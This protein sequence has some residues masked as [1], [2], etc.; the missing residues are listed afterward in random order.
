MKLFKKILIYTLPVIIIGGV[1]W[2]IISF[3]GKSILGTSDAKVLRAKEEISLNINKKDQPAVNIPA[4]KVPEFTLDLTTQKLKTLAGASKQ[5]LEELVQATIVHKAFANEKLAAEINVDQTGNKLMVN[6]KDIP[7]F[8]PGLYKLSLKLRTLEGEV[9]IEQDFTWGVIAVNSNKSIYKPGDVATIGMGVLNDAGETQCMTGQ[10]RADLWLTVTAPNGSIKEY[11]TESGSIKDSGE[12]G[13]I[14]VTNTPDAVAI[15]L[16]DDPGIYTMTVTARIKGG[17]KRTIKDYFKAEAAPAFD[18]ERTSFPTRIYP[19]ASYPVKL[20]ITAMTNDYSG[21]VED[22]VP[23]SFQ[24]SNING[25][26]HEEIQG[27]FKKIIWNTNLRRGQQTMFTYTINFPLVSPEFYLLGPLKIGD[28]EEARQWQIASDAVNSTT[29]VL[30]YEN[31]NGSNTYYRIWSGTAF[32]AQ[33][34]MDVTGDTPD[35]SRWF[36]E[37]TSPKTGEKL[38]AAFDNSSAPV[39]ATERIWMYRWNGSA[40]F[41]DFFEDVN[42]NDNTTRPM[43]IAYEEDSG[44][45]LFVFSN[46]TNQLRYRTKPNLGDGSTWSA[47]GS[48]GTALGARKRWVVAKPQPNSDNILVGYLNESEF[49]GALVWNG[50]SDTFTNQLNDDAGTATAAS[51]EQSF[52]IAWEKQSGTP[53]IFWGNT[54]QQLVY[55]EFTGGAWSSPAVLYTTDADAANDI[56][57][58]AAASDPDPTSNYI[59]LAMQE[60]LDD[61]ATDEAIDCEF[62]MWNGTGGETLPSPISCRSD[63]DGRLN[64]V[65]FEN[66]GGRAIF[67]YNTS[68]DGNS[69]AYR[70][71]QAGD[72]SP[73]TSTAITGDTTGTIESIQLYSDP[74]STS[75]LALFAADSNDADTDPDVYY[76]GWDGTSWDTIASQFGRIQG[77]GE[78]AEAYGFGFDR[79][80]ELQAAYRWITASGTTTISSALTTQDTAYTLTSANQQFRLRLLLYFPDT[81]LA[82][83]RNFI[84]QYVDPGTGTCADPTGGTPSTWTDVAAPGSPGSTEISYYDNS[85]PD[86]GDNL[87]G[88]ASLDP[89]YLSYD[90]SDSS[91]IE[92]DYEEGTAVSNPLFFTNSVSAMSNDQ[93]ALWDFSLID[94]TTFDRIAQ[95]YCFRVARA[96]GSNRLPLRVNVY[97]QINTAAES[98]VLIRGG[99]LIQGG[100]LLQ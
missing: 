71:W 1:V 7:G 38:V 94:N 69:L 3:S 93:V 58:V 81:L 46:T 99:S 14:T 5:K 53:M 2:G 61:D 79:N 16:I 4:N 28:F 21:T 54:T 75:I 56:E 55:S 41:E 11:S 70:T 74:N 45:A 87:V 73:G 82:S 63:N 80:L 27:D 17:E 84:L 78:N 20:S 72:A 68:A 97:P 36:V 34:D 13:P 96:S 25:G 85:T 37:K 66:T 29:G 32:N 9:N 39:A 10:D 92:Q 89:T 8:K 31:N 50:S 15:Y 91:Y 64:N 18:V 76:V 86:D 42:N 47:T 30:S 95:T 57:W 100:T 44:N 12:C 6:P 88:N 49:V 59:A 33:G 43:N 90:P 22:I 35:D 24:I 26:G 52:D 98:D 40:W 62:G 23:A 77:A 60:E 65:Q 83:G 48:A 67:V 51:D 19:K